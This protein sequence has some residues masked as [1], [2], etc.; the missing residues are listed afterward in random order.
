MDKALVR[1][2]ARQ[3]INELRFCY[4]IALQKEPELKGSLDVNLLISSRGA[5]NVAEVSSST[6]ESSTLERCVTNKIRRWMFPSLRE[7]VSAKILLPIT[8]SR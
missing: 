7:G 2:V 8:F 4:E 3:H 1:R 6:L 5:V